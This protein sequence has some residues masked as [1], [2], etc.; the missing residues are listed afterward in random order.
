MSERIFSDK[1]KTVDTEP[2]QSPVLGN[3]ETIDYTVNLTGYR[4]PFAVQVHPDAA[5]GTVQR[6]IVGLVNGVEVPVVALG[7]APVGVVT[8]DDFATLPYTRIRVR[9]VAGNPAPD[10]RVL[11]Q[12]NG[13]PAY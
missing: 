5:L 13:I 7:A 1:S 12:V 6:E 2:G 8:Q 4:A 9:L 10:G 3:G 11:V